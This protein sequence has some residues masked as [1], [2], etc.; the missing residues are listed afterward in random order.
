MRVTALFFGLVVV[1]AGHA[2]FAEPVRFASA[3]PPP[4]MLQQ[5]LLR[6]YGFLLPTP[7][8]RQIAGELYRP[9]GDGPFPAVIALHGCG[10]RR[11]AI[12]DALA[13]RGGPRAG[14]GASRS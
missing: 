6:T 7:A 14:V 12:D 1:L 13:R 11:Q 3:A 9:A 4:A 5:R 8:P 2:A 10:G